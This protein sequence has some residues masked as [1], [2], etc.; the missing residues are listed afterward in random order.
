VNFLRELPVFKIL[1]FSSVQS[2]AYVL[3]SKDYPRDHCI[4]K[5][6][7]ECEDLF[8]IESGNC[9]VVREVQDQ[10]LLRDTGVSAEGPSSLLNRKLGKG[11]V[12]G[13]PPAPPGFGEGD[14]EMLMSTDMAHLRTSSVS[15]ARDRLG[16]V[17]HARHVIHHTVHPRS[18]S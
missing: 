13:V 15:P 14:S 9:K 10:K 17:T 11:M 12:N 18:L 3:V 1:P 4:V 8:F 2:I 5:Q 7:G 6:G 16:H